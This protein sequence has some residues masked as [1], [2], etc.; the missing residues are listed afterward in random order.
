MRMPSRR[1]DGLRGDLLDA[2]LVDQDVEGVEHVHLR[3]VREPRRGEHVVDALRVLLSPLHVPVDLGEDRVAGA[4]GGADVEAHL[5][6]VGEVARRD[7]VGRQLVDGDVRRRPA[8]VPVLELAQADAEP[9]EDAPQ[10]HVVGP[11]GGLEAAAGIVGVVHQRPPSSS[12]RRTIARI[13]RTRL[14]RSGSIPSLRRLSI[15]RANRSS[16]R[17]EEG[18]GLRLEQVPDAEPELP[19]PPEPPDVPG[20]GLG[21]HVGRKVRREDVHA[22]GDALQ[23]VDVVR[24]ADARGTADRAG[25]AGGADPDR[26][27]AQDLLEEPRAEE[28]D[29]LPRR[30]VHRVGDRAGAGAAPALDAVAHPVAVGKRPRPGP[31]RPP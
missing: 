26:A 22:R 7:R 28:G 20:E 30:D 29:D 3:R 23:G 25:V 31:S 19:V 14:I 12:A 10:R 13:S 5:L 11:A 17:G 2:D 18:G 21:H 16:P 15:A 24:H 4:A 9:L 1:R 8:A 27:A 6:G